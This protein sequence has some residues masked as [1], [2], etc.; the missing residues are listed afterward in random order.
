MSS[1]TRFDPRW[2]GCPWRRT[3]GEVLLSGVP[4]VATLYS[5]MEGAALERLVGDDASFSVDAIAECDRITGMLY[6]T[7]HTE[8]H[9]PNAAAAQHVAV[10]LLWR[11][12][13][14]PH[15]PAGGRN[16][17]W[18]AFRGVSREQRDEL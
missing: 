18:V 3:L 6:E 5:E 11:T 15:A 10:E 14:N 9:V 12:E 4:A 1:Q 17:Y 7:L 2:Q 8:H 13:R 16:A